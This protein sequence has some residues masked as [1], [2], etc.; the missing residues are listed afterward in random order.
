[1]VTEAEAL[2][3]KVQHRPTSSAQLTS[4]SMG[5][6]RRERLFWQIHYAR[7]PTR[8]ICTLINPIA[9]TVDPEMSR[10]T[11]YIDNDSDRV[12]M[13][14]SVIL[15]SFASSQSSLHR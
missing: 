5:D 6:T 8:Y 1:M 3:P 7:P 9:C 2:R 15:S 12:L 10:N 13:N 14:E 4:S 11:A